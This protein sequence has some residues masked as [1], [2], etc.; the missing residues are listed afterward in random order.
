[1]AQVV[2][3]PQ[4]QCFTLEESGQLAKLEYGESDQAIEFTS[5][6]VPF[7][8][9]GRGYAEQLVKVGLEWARGESKQISS[10]C[11]YVD[12]FLDNTDSQR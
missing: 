12:R 9:R 11:W 2:H 8:L 5:T 10:L 1:M 7:R 3:H 4:T 6:Y